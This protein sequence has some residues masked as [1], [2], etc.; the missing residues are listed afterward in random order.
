MNI[1]RQFQDTFSARKE[2][3]LASPNVQCV[4]EEIW[5]MKAQ[6]SSGPTEKKLS[7]ITLIS[8]PL[9]IPEIGL[10][11]ECA[12]IS[13]WLL[14]K[15][16]SARNPIPDR[17]RSFCPERVHRLSTRQVKSNKGLEE[18]RVADDRM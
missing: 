6:V 17:K 16:S 4:D 5:I 8:Q 14:T 3:T 12:N 15:I 1:S 2:K 11:N 10:P 13:V 9:L 7:Q 18:K